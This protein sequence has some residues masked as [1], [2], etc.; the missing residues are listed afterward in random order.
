ML[1]FCILGLSFPQ[2]EAIPNWGII[3]CLALGIFI[4]CFGIR[5]EDISEIKFTQVFFFY[6]CRFILVPIASYF[7][8][9]YFNSPYALG[10]FL[11]I[12]L[13]PGVSSPAM[14]RLFGGN[15]S[16]AF[17]LTILGNMLVPFVLP[18]LLYTFIGTEAQLNV[19]EMFYMLALSIMV[20]IL[21]FLLLRKNKSVQN[22][23]HKEGSFLTAIFI[24]LNIAA[25]VAK[26][27]T[28]I[29]EDPLALIPI[30]IVSSLAYALMYI[31]GWLFKNKAPLRNKIAFSLGSG[32]INISLGVSIALLYFPPHISLF[33]IVGE[34]PWI[35]AFTPFKMLA[36]SK[37][38][39]HIKEKEYAGA[40]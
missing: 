1:F 30:L 17:A 39:S 22:F 21:M 31:S 3:S 24:G 33:L 16:L 9:Q 19:T 12:A 25:A 11:L 14:N 27:R 13:P 2:F 26:R 36:Q 34:I 28:Q 40:S 4:A 7:I 18:F 23:I 6:L 35:L 37:M 15:V 29:W 20:P 5:S 32:A 8:L 38:T 10:L